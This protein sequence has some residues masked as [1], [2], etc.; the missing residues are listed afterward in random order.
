MNKMIKIVIF[1][2][3]VLVL[4]VVLF[5][6]NFVRN[7]GTTMD[8]VIKTG[9]TEGQ[10]DYFASQLSEATTFENL[11][12]RGKLLIQA[13]EYSKAIN[14]YNEIF[15]KAKWQGD[16]ARI[17]FR[18]ADI[19]EKMRDYKKALEYIIII[20]DEYISEEAKEPIVE[21]AKYLEYASEGNY[22]MAVKHA[23][24]AVEADA[25]LPAR[26]KGGRQIYIDRLND[27]KA[28]KEYIESL[29]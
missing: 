2:I 4:I 14:Y 21:R 28:S 9:M 25:K 12:R 6:M 11:M 5:Q 16:R 27:I 1:C 15:D 22:E 8:N 19:Y 13:G 17:I 3:I 10:K 26:P 23:Q 29:K 7:S 20:R 24:L 18:L